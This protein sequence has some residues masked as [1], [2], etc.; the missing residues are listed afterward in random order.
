MIENKKRAILIGAGEMEGVLLSND[1]IASGKSKQDKEG[2]CT[3]KNTDMVM[4]LDGGLVFCV[5]NGIELDYIMGDFDSLPE[6]RMGLLDEYPREKIIRLP[7]EKD[8]TDMLAAIKFAADKGIREFVICG[9]L[10]GRLSHTL[11]NIQC[12]MYLKEQGMQ[13]V[14]LG[15]DTEVFL[16]QNERYVF[17]GRENGYVSIFSYLEQAKGI[18]LKNLKYELENGVLTDAFP[19]GVSNEF[20]K[21]KHAEIHVEEGTVIVVCESK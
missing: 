20:I 3:I 10:G 4:A 12:L 11:A 5:K 7:K 2:I 1:R 9:G 14:L 8:D 18:T 17:T 19:I 15:G 16:L 21:G 6:E 13:G